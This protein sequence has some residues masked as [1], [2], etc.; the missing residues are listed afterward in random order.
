MPS[1][2]LFP[3]NPPQRL[4]RKSGRRAGQQGQSIVL[5]TLMFIALV[6]F[7]GLAT[8][9]G[10][11]YVTYGQFRRAI[12]AAALGAASQYRQA[13]PDSEIDANALQFIQLQGITPTSYSVEDCNEISIA[14]GRTYPPSGPYDES[15]SATANPDPAICDYPVRK[16][17]RVE[18]TTEAS[19]VFMPMFGFF[20]KVVGL[21]AEAVAEAASL[22]I[23]LV[24]DISPSMTYDAPIGGS[25][26]LRDPAVCD[27]IAY[28]GANG[29]TVG[30]PNGLPAI[31]T[32]DTIQYSPVNSCR[33]FEWVRDAAVQ[34]VDKFVKFPY[35]R[36]GIAA[37]SNSAELIQS[38]GSGDAVDKTRTLEKLRDLDIATAMTS[39][40]SYD[41]AC[42]FGLEDRG[43]IGA[44]AATNT[45]DG[46]VEAGDDLEGNARSNA[47]RFIILLSDGAVNGS[48]PNA[49]D[50]AYYACPKNI[51]PTSPDYDQYMEYN[52]VENTRFRVCD[53][54]DARLQTKHLSTD[55]L[56]DADDYARDMASSVV[57]NS[58]TVIFTVGLGAE[59]TVNP[60]DADGCPTDTD[61]SPIDGKPDGLFS[62]SFGYG[63]A[64]APYTLC[65][66]DRLPN[67]EQLLRYIADMGDGNGVFYTDPGPCGRDNTT[68]LYYTAIGESCGNYFYAAS[69]SQLLTLFNQIAENIFTRITK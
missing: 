56:Y 45:G 58:Q 50:N 31:Y 44:C 12:D 27:A 36:V 2:P 43:I 8:D 34:F 9:A 57:T 55:I 18:A 40:P 64:V 63:A 59:V 61:L 24:I 32:V 21:R 42:N 1:F 29:L 62:T 3:L 7:I 16:L 54:G 5:L 6:A 67:G 20:P 33:P 49:A 53:D 35:D 25:P 26:D 66:A 17:V 19:L 15:S 28:N 23:M 22:D 39:P 30:D 11:I 51:V 14:A 52:A 4:A 65:N 60:D 10:I 47:L 41:P 13:R 46:L 37:F 48:A 69:G 68:G 38:V